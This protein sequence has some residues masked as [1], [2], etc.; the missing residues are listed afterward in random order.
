MQLQELK[1]VFGHTNG[2]REKSKTDE[3]TDMKFDLVILILYR[4]AL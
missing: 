4:N 1:L 2:K 3:Q